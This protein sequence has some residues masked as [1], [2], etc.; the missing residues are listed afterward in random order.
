[1]SDGGRAGG[2]DRH[3]L[4]AWPCLRLWLRLS[5]LVWDADDLTSVIISERG[6]ACG[7][8]MVACE[9]SFKFVAS[10]SIARVRGDAFSVYTGFRRMGRAGAFGACVV[11]GS[12]LQGS[13]L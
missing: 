10:V 8:C 1:M 5:R 12:A 4:V 3:D 11:C 13:A 6:V 2:Y 7:W 9:H